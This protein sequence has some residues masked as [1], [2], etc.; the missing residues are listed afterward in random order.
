MK[1]KP[2]IKFMKR[3]MNVKSISSP[4]INLASFRLKVDQDNCATIED[5]AKLAFSWHFLKL[6]AVKPSQIREEIIQ[7]M[8][9]V[10]ELRPK[11]VLEIGT[12]MG[13]T[14]YLFSKVA[15]PNATIISVD[16]PRGC[17]DWKI[18]LYKAFARGNQKIHLIRGNSH[19]QLT[20]SKV[21][22][23]IDG[24]MVE[25]LFI[26]GDHSYKGVKKD[27]EM[28]APLVRSGGIMAYH[29]IVS[30]PL[31]SVGG[32]PKFWNEIKHNYISYMEIVKSWEQEGCG[33]GVI[34][35]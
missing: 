7:L 6:L 18:P 12:A 35:L 34:F 24:H 2:P 31:E 1:L 13:G 19:D 11:V 14:L 16:L 23:V 32:V 20:L 25:I 3:L 21:K 30:G 10:A 27:F 33:I 22:E 17:P 28:Y 9:L 15:T 26:D 8:T 4:I 29:D 5:H